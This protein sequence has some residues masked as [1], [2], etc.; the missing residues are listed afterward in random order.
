MKT[1]RLL[2]MMLIL[3]VSLAVS[4]QDLSSSLAAW[5]E[6]ANDPALVEFF[7]GLILNIGIQVE[8]TGETFSAYHNGQEFSLVPGIGDDIEFVLDIQLKDVV[9]LIDHA[10]DATI[11]DHETFRILSV[12]FTPLTAHTLKD[13][14]LAR[15]T[16]KWVKFTKNLIHVYL[17]DPKGEREVAHTLVYINKE[18]IVIPGIHGTALRTYVMTPK[19]AVE[20]QKKVQET[21]QGNTKKDWKAFR[22]WYVDWSKRMNIETSPAS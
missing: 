18:W 13:P 10:K 3:Q 19:Q 5:Q 22:K 8:E 17:A 16:A 21:M 11:D 14:N 2:A 15:Q 20:Y 12:L 4:A 1:I 6:Y 9:N 7:E